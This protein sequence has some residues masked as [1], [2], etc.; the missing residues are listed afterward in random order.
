MYAV[1]LSAARGDKTLYRGPKYSTCRTLL[2]AMRRRGLG[3]RS[4]CGAVLMCEV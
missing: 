2:A 1:I 3:G 4:P